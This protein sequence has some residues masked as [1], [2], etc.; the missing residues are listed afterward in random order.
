[1]ITAPVAS[2]PFT[3]AQTRR[4]G[5]TNR[6]DTYKTTNSTTTKTYDGGP[7]AGDVSKGIKLV[8][9]P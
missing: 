4:T 9:I 5:S 7:T 6:T 8:R 1:M 2:G 3:T